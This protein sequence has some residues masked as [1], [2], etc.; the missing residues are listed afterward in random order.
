MSTREKLSIWIYTLAHCDH[1]R[2]CE[3]NIH[4]CIIRF[5]KCA[6]WCCYQIG[7]LWLPEMQ[8]T[9][10]VE[11]HIWK[12]SLGVPWW[13]GKLRTWHGHCCGM[14]CCCGSGVILGPRTSAWW[15][16]GKKKKRKRWKQEK[17]WRTKPALLCFSPEATPVTSAYNLL[18]RTGHMTSTM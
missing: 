10:K 16:C 15:K 7:P 4:C 12:S 6:F 14:R 3:R 5:L 2:S 9:S 18:V 8:A 13:L 1:P 11:C 17:A